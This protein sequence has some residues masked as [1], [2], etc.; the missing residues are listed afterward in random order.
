MAIAIFC[1]VSHCEADMSISQSS[2]RKLK[3]AFE[4]QKLQSRGLSLKGDL[5][6]AWCVVV[7]SRTLAGIP[8]NLLATY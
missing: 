8:M 6:A 1:C 3:H 4:Y 5:T 2:R 7:A